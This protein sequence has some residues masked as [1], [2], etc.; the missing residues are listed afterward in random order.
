MECSSLLLTLLES[1]FA[2]NYASQQKKR[3]VEYYF[4]FGELD[5][6]LNV[7]SQ[8]NCFGLYDFVSDFSEGKIRNMIEL[9]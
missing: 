6:A 2:R 5:G 7:A 8:I 1:Y 9:T 4:S 3:A